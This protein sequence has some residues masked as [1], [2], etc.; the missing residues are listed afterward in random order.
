MLQMKDMIQVE[1]R[2]SEETLQNLS[3]EAMEDLKDTLKYCEA[4]L[5]SSSLSSEQLLDA[6]RELAA[7]SDRAIRIIQAREA[8]WR[9]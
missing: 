7:A 2:N 1:K 5:E 4:V 8:V 6:D 3:N 9:L